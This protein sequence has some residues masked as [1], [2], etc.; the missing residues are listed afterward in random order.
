M[1]KPKIQISKGKN[2]ITHWK[3]WLEHAPP[4]K[5]EEH[6]KAGRSA[7]EMA[8]FWLGE[9][10]HDPN[11]TITSLL[12]SSKDFG[13]ISEWS[14][15]PEARQ[16]FDKY[17]GN[18]RNADLLIH[19]KDERGAF[20][21]AVEGKADEPFGE[22]VN[23]VLSN[24]LEKKAE[25]KNSN[26]IGRIEG[27]VAML[28]S[29][30][31][32]GLPHISKLHYQLLTATAGALSYAKKQKHDRVILLI[33]EFKSN[34]GNAKKYRE[35]HEVLNAFVLRLSEGCI[36]EVEENKLYGPLE[37]LEGSSLKL[38]IGKIT[39]APVG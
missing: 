10:N 12:E 23:K 21:L 38:Y 25:N 15:E 27:L 13:K 37:I 22:T 30:K 34:S 16:P 7:K 35:N 4:A 33:Q 39:C 14:A 18:T 29:K 5:K 8:H 28:F 1:N 31:S 11:G 24:A 32:R 17:G 26:A 9:Q 19:A 20:T 6:W 3:E 2:P 36:K